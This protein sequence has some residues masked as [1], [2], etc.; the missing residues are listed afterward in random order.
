MKKWESAARPWSD[1]E[2]YYQLQLWKLKLQALAK[3]LK[4]GDTKLALEG[5]YA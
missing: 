4:R 3:E 5:R 2:A 1:L